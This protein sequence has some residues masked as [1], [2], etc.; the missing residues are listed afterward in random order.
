MGICIDI[1]NLFNRRIEKMYHRRCQD[2]PTPKE[3]KHQSQS[4]A[5][6][7]RVRRQLYLL[8]KFKDYPWYP[9]P[10]VLNPLSDDRKQSP[11]ERSNQN[12]EK[13]RN[14]KPDSVDRSGIVAVISWCG[15]IMRECKE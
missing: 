11:N 14:S 6:I 9:F 3:P 7:D 12:D 8:A 1:A 5:L 13:R 2:H 4:P 10:Q 15:H